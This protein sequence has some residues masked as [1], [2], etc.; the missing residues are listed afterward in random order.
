M[1]IS[2][3]IEVDMDKL[4]ISGLGNGYIH[5]LSDLRGLKAGHILTATVGD[6]SA[7]ANLPISNPTPHQPSPGSQGA[8]TLQALSADLQTVPKTRE[9]MERQRGMQEMQSRLRSGAQHVMIYERPEVNI[10]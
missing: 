3:L 4:L 8:I 1:Q 2:S 9:E 10:T 7:A 6:A 5:D